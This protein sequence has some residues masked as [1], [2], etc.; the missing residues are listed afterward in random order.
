VGEAKGWRE[1]IV[2]AETETPSAALRASLGG[3]QEQVPVPRRYSESRCQTYASRPKQRQLRLAS[4][5]YGL[6]PHGGT[7]ILAMPIPH[8]RIERSQTAQRDGV[9]GRKEPPSVRTQHTLP[10]TMSP[11]HRRIL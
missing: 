11:P 8:R 6:I 1:E 7:Q 5:V 3:A 4:H 10:L 2:E 9:P